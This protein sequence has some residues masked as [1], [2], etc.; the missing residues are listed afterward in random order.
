MYVP[1]AGRGQKRSPDALEL[2]LRMV[3]TRH[4]G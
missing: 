3:V 1:V 4:V 2:E